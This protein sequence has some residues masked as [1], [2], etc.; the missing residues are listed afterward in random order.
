MA[1]IN[2][3]PW[4]AELRKQH[5]KTFLT[6]VAFA[7]IMGV[8]VM[9]VFHMYMQS[10]IEDKSSRIK[11]IEGKI[12]S[13]EAKIAEI[14]QLDQKRE[15]LK[16]KMELIQELQRSRPQV[17]HLFDA[18][19]RVIPEGLHLTSIV[20][21][22]NHLDITGSSESNTRIASLLRNIDDSEWLGKA[23]VSSFTQNDKSNIP[24]Q[25]FSVVAEVLS[26]K[27]EKGDE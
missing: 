27:S 10:I 9:Y 3:L 6:Y 17:V 11:F 8:V 20:R 23:D 26:P 5:Q 21:I 15:E 25:G 13:V 19:P 2:L 22:G 4:R 24:S 18:I 16:N 1:Q 12:A 14:K 7:A